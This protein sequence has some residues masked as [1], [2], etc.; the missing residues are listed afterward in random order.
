MIRSLVIQNVA[1]IERLEF[2]LGPGLTVLTGETGAGK[3]IIIGSLNLLLGARSSSDLIRTGADEAVVEAEIDGPVL[4]GLSELLETAGI[5]LDGP[6]LIRRHL[7]SN[8]RSKAVVNGRAVPLSLLRQLGSRMAAIYGQHE[9]QTLLDE[10]RHLGLLDEYGGLGPKLKLTA[11]EFAQVRQLRSQLDELTRRATEAGAREDYL[12][13]LVTELEAANLSVDEEQQLD[14]QR[15]VLANAVRLIQAADQAQ[16]ELVGDQGGAQDALARAAKALDEAARLDP[17]AEQLAG[18][19]HDALLQVEEAARAVGDYGSGL[20]QDPDQ[21]ELVEARLEALSALKRKHRTDVPG[22]IE[23]LGRSRDE[24]ESV[25]NLDSRLTKMRHELEQA[26]GRL[27]Q[28][29]DELSA[30][31]RQAA[32]K[33]GKLV[34]AELAQLSMPKSRFVVQVEQRPGGAG[35][36]GDLGDVSVDASGA[37]QVAFNISPN[38]GEEPRP[39]ARIASGG[40]LSRIML[41]LKRIL[42]R[43]EPVD[44]MI[45]DEVDSGIGGQT[46]AVVGAKLAQVAVDHQ[47]IVIT[48][49]PQI[50][51]YGQT[52]FAVRKRVHQGRTTT[53]L[54]RLDPSQ[55]IEEIAR[56][57]GGEPIHDSSRAAAQELLSARGGR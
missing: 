10:S 1:I 8:G 52:H 22:L 5:E 42:Q 55:R 15:K 6:L 46:A 53:L 20:S 4:D 28:A 3:S 23:L 27:R 29:A 32:A 44:T 36:P 25:V 16:A 17:R 35:G 31:R 49:L 50:A 12:R 39:L 37:D 2:D 26:H 41:G 56:L 11:R 18:Q 38:P 43:A 30:A 45:F 57:I 47:V 33:L 48:H 40:E 13:F 24:L 7:S 14:V 54:S 51:S 19:L 21:L 34:E 9:H